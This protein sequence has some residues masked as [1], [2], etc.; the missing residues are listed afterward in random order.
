[1]CQER[2]RRRLQERQRLEND[3]RKE[4]FLILDFLINFSSFFFLVSVFVYISTEGE[5]ILGP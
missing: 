3:G 4:V 2:K 1:L 5:K